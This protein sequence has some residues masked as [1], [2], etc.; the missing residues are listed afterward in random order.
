MTARSW[1][2]GRA[3]KRLAST[4]G[5]L[6]FVGTAKR[7]RW[8]WLLPCLA[9]GFAYGIAAQYINTGKSSDYST[10]DQFSNIP[11]FVLTSVVTG[12]LLWALTFTMAYR[13][14]LVFDG[15]LAASIATKTSLRVFPWTTIDE[16]SIA[17]FTA[18]NGA[19]A[20]ALISATPLVKIG[21]RGEH[22]L[23]FKA[24][25]GAAGSAET[26]PAH[27]FIF[28]SRE[29]PT[30]LV[31]AI[32]AGMIQAGN[33]AAGQAVGRALPPQA[34]TAKIVLD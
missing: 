13:R 11:L 6:R 27:Y 18:A 8:T 15:G 10:A 28:E 5:N 26:I 2:V 30:A 22:A 31:Q 34:L 3:E 20:S 32:S 21:L 14:L 9:L 23:I 17:A 24:D 29:E 19:S 7:I 1:L 25:A 33:T 16:T 12:F 4:L